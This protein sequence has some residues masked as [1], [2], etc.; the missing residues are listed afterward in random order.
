M[1]ATL[2]YVEDGKEAWMG[3]ALIHKKEQESYNITQYVNDV[4]RRNT[5]VLMELKTDGTANAAYTYGYNAESTN[6]NTGYQLPSI[7]E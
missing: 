5:E 1:H 7:P 4:N 6:T 3:L 2:D